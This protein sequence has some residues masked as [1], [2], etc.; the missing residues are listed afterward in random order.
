[1]LLVELVFEPAALR[2][3]GG[4]VAWMMAERSPGP[5]SAVA[6]IWMLVNPLA[7]SRLRY[8]AVVRVPVAQVR[9]WASACCPGVEAVVG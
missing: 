9:S 3:Y 6:V 2:A 8:S 7:S 1:M 5:A 4:L